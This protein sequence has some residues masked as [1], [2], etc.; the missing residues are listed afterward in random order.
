V[1]QITVGTIIKTADAKIENIIVATVIY[2]GTRAFFNEFTALFGDE[3]RVT[4][5]IV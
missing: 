3:Q 2:G 5:I 1:V 4:L